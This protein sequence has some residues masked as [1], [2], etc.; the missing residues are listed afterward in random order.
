MGLIDQDGAFF[1]KCL[2]TYENIVFVFLL[3]VDDLGIALVLAVVVAGAEQR[4]REFLGAAVF[5]ELCRTGVGC[6]DPVLVA[7]VAGVEEIKV[8]AGADGAAG[9]ASLIVIKGI[10]SEADAL[11]LPADQVGTGHV[12]PVFE[13]VYSSPG[14]PLIEKVPGSIVTGESVRVT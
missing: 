11:V 5:A 1:I 7:V 6:T 14:T 12:I 10:G 8:V 3:I 9:M 13:A 4:L 2:R